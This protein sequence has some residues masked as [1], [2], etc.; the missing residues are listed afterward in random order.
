MS[1]AMNLFDPYIPMQAIAGSL[2]S[3]CW[4]S[5]AVG[6]IASAYFSGSLIE[7]FGTRGV[8]ALT[9]IFPLIVSLTA[10]LITESPVRLRGHGPEESVAGTD[11]SQDNS[12][13]R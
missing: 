10:F 4:G 13:A 2:Q 8:F 5:S 1:L 7:S 9:A 3:L 6:G 12:E 11:W